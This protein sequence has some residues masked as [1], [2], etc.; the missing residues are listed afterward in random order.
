MHING[1]K[2]GQFLVNTH[3]RGVPA[4]FP[5]SNFRA[6]SVG[7]IW[8]IDFIDRCINNVPTNIKLVWNNRSPHLEEKSFWDGV[9]TPLLAIE[10]LRFVSF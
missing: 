2:I 7:P 10:G 8:K 6:K 3:G 4:P 5:L 1:L 9:E